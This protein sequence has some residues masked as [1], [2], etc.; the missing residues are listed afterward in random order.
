LHPR[1]KAVGGFRVDVASVLDEAAE[2]GLDMSA[3]T[4]ETV[5]EIEMAEG[6][7]EIVAPKKAD[8]AAA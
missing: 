8:D 4:A 6:G 3:R 1:V 5:V 2:R 7:I